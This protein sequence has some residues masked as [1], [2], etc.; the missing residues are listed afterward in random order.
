MAAPGEAGAAI[1]TDIEKVDLRDTTENR[2][3]PQDSTPA[4]PA[5]VYVAS[6][7]K[8]KRYRRTKAAVGDIRQAIIDIL[9]AYHPMTVRQVFYQLTVRGAITKT[10][11]EYQRTV[12]RLLV[13]MRAAGEIPFGWIADISRWVRKPSTFVGLD[14]YLKNAAKLYRRDLWASQDVYLE[15][16]VEKEALAGVL[17]DVTDEYDFTLMPSRGYSSLSFLHGAAQ[18]IQAH[19]RP[20]FIYQFGDL[21]PSGVDIAR[22]IEAKLRRYAPDSEIHFERV[23]VTRQQA[24]EWGLPTR[25]TKTTDTRAKKFKGASVELDAIPPDR[26]RTLVREVIERHVDQGQLR[27][28]KVAEESE[29]KTLERW[30]DLV[31]STS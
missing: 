27:V 15:V 16:W 26:L 8:P 6:T 18:T 30:A 19:G 9:E 3:I 11:A 10:E 2:D 7:T 29:R 5:G 21:D 31:G 24:D 12:V 13:Q 25:P 1:G 22:D 20:A 4:Q 17:V 23:A 14:A 28:L